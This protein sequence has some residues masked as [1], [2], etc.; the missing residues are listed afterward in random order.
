MGI[1]SKVYIRKLKSYLGTE[2]LTNLSDEQ[3]EKLNR[4]VVDHPDTDV[5]GELLVEIGGKGSASK[6]IVVNLQKTLKEVI[7]AGIE[8]VIR[9]QEI[10]N[11]TMAKLE[12]DNLTEDD[13]QQLNSLLREF[14]Q[15]LRDKMLRNDQLRLAIAGGAFLTVLLV[16]G[17]FMWFKYKIDC[18][19]IQT[20]ALTG[21]KALLPGG[22]TV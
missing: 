18:L 2:N 8:D 13:R 19:K 9:L 14:A 10:I 11:Q 1:K 15:I 21:G 22:R 12:S 4:F 16:A 7:D 3:L 20:A 17:G 6:L 5:L